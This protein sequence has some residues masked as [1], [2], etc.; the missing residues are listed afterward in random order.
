MTLSATINT[1][2]SIERM[3]SAKNTPFSDADFNEFLQ[4]ASSEANIETSLDLSLSNDVKTFFKSLE[5]K[6]ITKE[7]KTKNDAVLFAQPLEFNKQTFEAK[8]N[9]KTDSKIETVNSKDS[10]NQAETT[11]T[12]E[13][14]S[15]QSSEVEKNSQESLIDDNALEELNIE[16]IDIDMNNS[17]SDSSLLSRQTPEEQGIKILLNQDAKSFEVQTSQPASAVAKPTAVTPSKIIDQVAKHLETL[18]NTSKVDI[19]LNPESLGKVTIQLVKSP[20]GLS[21]QFTT[22]T[23]EA[24]NLLMKGLD[25]LKETLTAHGVGVENVSVKINDTE[26]SEYNP[27]WTDQEGSRGGNKEQTKQNRKENEEGL[28]ERVME[29]R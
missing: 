24:R 8:P 10:N 9:T 19:V 7:K 17:E 16:S 4:K 25:G 28:F 21:A 18:N 22:A 13:V 26:K 27:D 12:N 1:L 2:N 15:E 3:T 14:E 20:T 23:Q 29:E 5:T 6:E 11:S